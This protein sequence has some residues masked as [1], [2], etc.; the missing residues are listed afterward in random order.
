MNRSQIESKIADSKAKFRDFTK[1]QPERAF[2]VG[3]IV[4][5]LLVLT[6]TVLLPILFVLASLVVVFWFLGDSTEK[7]LEISQPQLNGSGRHVVETE[8]VELDSQQNEEVE[9]EPKAYKPPKPAK[10]RTKPRTKNAASKS[11]AEK[12]SKSTGKKESS[13]KANKAGKTTRK[14][15]PT[16]KIKSQIAASKKKTAKA[17]RKTTR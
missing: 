15:K 13:A 9:P 6:S 10:V 1:A 4:G 17:T 11:K 16:A 5:A 12:S 14:S 2:L 3:V 7:E 8:Q